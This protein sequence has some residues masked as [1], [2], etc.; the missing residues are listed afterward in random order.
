MAVAGVAGVVLVAAALM[1]TSA[2]VSAQEAQSIFNGQDLDG[3]AHVGPGRVYVEDNYQLQ[4]MLNN[5]QPPGGSESDQG[6][7]FLI[8]ANDQIVVHPD[9][10][11]I[12]ETWQE[13][14]DPLTEHEPRGAAEAPE[15]AAGAGIDAALTHQIPLPPLAAGGATTR[16]WAGPPT[17][18]RARFGLA[19]TLST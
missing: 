4:S 12:L 8:N 9:S 14:E 17:A 6:V 2:P 3:W 15:A 1:I 19:S 13:N 10:A 11:Q 7:G 18:Q 5:L 16:P